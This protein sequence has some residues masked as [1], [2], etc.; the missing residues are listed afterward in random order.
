[1][2]TLRA[3]VIRAEPEPLPVPRHLVAD[4]RRVN[5][6]VE[7]NWGA[8]ARDFVADIRGQEHAPYLTFRDGWRYQQ[9]IEAVCS[10]HLWS[11][12]PTA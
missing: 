4:L 2:R 10:G 9:A 1:M 8:F 3:I 7:N 12:L 5:G 6:D 11:D